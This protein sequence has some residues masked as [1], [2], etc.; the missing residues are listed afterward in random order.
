MHMRLTAAISGAT[1][2]AGVIADQSLCETVKLENPNIPIDPNV[3]FP[4]LDYAVDVSGRTVVRGAPWSNYCFDGSGAVSVFDRVDGGWAVMGAPYD[5][6]NGTDSGSAYL[7]RA[8]PDYS[9]NGVPDICEC[10]GDIDG[11]YDVDLAELS[12]LL[13]RYGVVRP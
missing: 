7:F 6:D 2:V 8:G 1:L 10:P 5:D 12:A 11:D 3:P 4:R 13:E 9:G